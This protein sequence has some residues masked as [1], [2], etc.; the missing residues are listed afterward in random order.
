MLKLDSFSSGT[1]IG[2][3]AG[4]ARK[5]RANRH[6]TGHRH[7]AFTL[8]ELLVVIAIIAMLA[9]ILFPVFSRA[10]ENGRRASCASNLKQIGTGLM[11]YVSDYDDVLPTDRLCEDPDNYS[12]SNGTCVEG[13]DFVQPYVKN[14]RLFDCPSAPQVNHY[15]LGLTNQ[16][17][18]YAMNHTYFIGGDNYVGAMSDYQ[19]GREGSVKASRVEVPSTTV[20]IA[21]SGKDTGYSTPIDFAWDRSD[22]PSIGTANGIS[23]LGNDSGPV[24]RHL[25]RSNILYCDGHVKSMSLTAL[26]ERK[27]I[28]ADTI[29][30]QFTIQDD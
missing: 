23:F 27:V 5:S 9:A 30:T 18:S 24:A 6:A 29:L 17:G 16:Y 14:E 28:G 15:E 1:R 21:E 11:Q 2:N 4:N 26:G 22:P 13:M 10:R 25:S 12:Y 20:W 3:R 19:T 7:S 8:I